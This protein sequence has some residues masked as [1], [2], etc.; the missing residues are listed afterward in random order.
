M[1]NHSRNVVESDPDEFEGEVTGC[2]EEEE[3][4]E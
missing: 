3:E 2:E 1:W 4:E